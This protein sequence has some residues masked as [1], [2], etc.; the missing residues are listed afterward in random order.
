MSNIIE[1]IEQKLALS[2]NRH[3]LVMLIR[4]P[5]DDDTIYF[6]PTVNYELAL[7]QGTEKTK[8]LLS[9]LSEN[10]TVFHL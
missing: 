6:F 7:S 4:Y 10:K 8:Q 1:I 2:D 3:T 5:D 9:K